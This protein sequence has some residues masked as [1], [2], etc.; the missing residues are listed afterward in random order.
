MMPKI[1]EG[2]A[3]KVWIVPSEIGKALEGLGSTMNELRGIPAESRGS[4]GPRRHGATGSRQLPRAVADH[5][6]SAPA[7]RSRRPSPRRESAANPGRR[8]GRRATD[9]AIDPGNV[10]ATDPEAPEGEPAP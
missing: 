9:P 4:S 3:N 10:P 7:R 6:R 1:A 5:E 2:N 8:Q